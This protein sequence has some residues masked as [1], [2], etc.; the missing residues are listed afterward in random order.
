[1]REGQRRRVG[2]RVALA[3]SEEHLS[4]V[5]HVA[6]H[7][8]LDEGEPAAH[9]QQ[10]LDRDGV[11]GVGG[12]APLGH[13]RA[14]RRVDAPL[15]HRDAEGRVQHALGHRPG[16][17][18]A[19]LVV[20]VGVALGD[21]AAVLDDRHGVGEPELLGLRHGVVEGVLEG[22]VLDGGRRLGHLPGVR[23]P[24]GVGGGGGERAQV[25]HGGRV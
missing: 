5:G 24:G 23:G 19:G 16:D 14:R 3:G 9:A 7:V 13:R 10:L 1:M 20:V 6:V 11:P 12:V 18:G 2:R 21:D 22:A 8:V 25:R 4:H 17:V 15:A